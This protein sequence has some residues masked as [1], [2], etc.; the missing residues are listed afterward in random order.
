MVRVQKNRAGVKKTRWMGQK[1]KVE[2][3]KKY[4]S[5]LDE[6]GLE[7][8]LYYIAPRMKPS[9]MDAAGFEPEGEGE[10]GH[11]ST[12]LYNLAERRGRKTVRHERSWKLPPMHC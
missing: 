9:G 7:L 5:R 12:W 3:S 2:G 11:S 1:N 10:R 6:I 8:N 4:G